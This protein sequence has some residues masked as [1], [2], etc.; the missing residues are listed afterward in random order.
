MN[1]CLFPL[2]L[3]FTSLLIIC[4]ILAVSGQEIPHLSKIKLPAT[5]AQLLTPDPAEPQIEPAA[6]NNA[7][8]EIEVTGE[9]DTLPLSTPIY[10]ID[11]EEIEKQGSTSVA[12]ILKKCLDLPSM[13]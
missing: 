8:I 6:P 1:N 12:D 5:N 13:M 7:D 4:P 2:S 9:K 11:K 10:V 3:T